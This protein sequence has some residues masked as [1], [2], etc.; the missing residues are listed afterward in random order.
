M[1]PRARARSRRLTRGVALEDGPA[2]FDEV[3]EQEG[4][5]SNR[6]YLVSLREGRNREVRPLWDP[7][8]AR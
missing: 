7:T 8:G 4:E 1:A 3:V 2:R 6:W 5:G